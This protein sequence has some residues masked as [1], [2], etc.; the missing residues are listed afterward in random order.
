MCLSIYN[1]H[2]YFYPI[3]YFSFSVDLCFVFLKIMSNFVHFGVSVDEHEGASEMHCRCF[4]TSLHDLPLAGRHLLI[5]SGI[6]LF[7]IE[8]TIIFSPNSYQLVC[9]FVFVAYKYWKHFFLL[10][11]WRFPKF[12]KNNTDVIIRVISVWAG[13]K[14]LAFTMK[15]TKLQDPV[16][17][18]GYLCF[19]KFDPF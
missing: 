6:A 10:W 13:G 16:P 14:M 1:R 11:L 4:C 3:I 8:M 18:S 17:K 12:E 19:I 5:I 9:G 15:R 2:W 7:N